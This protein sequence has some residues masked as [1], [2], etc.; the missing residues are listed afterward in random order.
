MTA[1]ELSPPAARPSPITR[2]RLIFLG[3]VVLAGSACVAL[4]VLGYIQPVVLG[5][6]QGLTEFMPV[7]SAAH[8]ILM[9]WFFH[10][11]SGM[12][13][14]LNFDLALHLGTLIALLCYFW[15]DWAE[16]LGSAPGTVRWGLR[17]MRGDHFYKPS[18]GEH[19]LI[20]MILATIPGIL[21]GVLLEPYVQHGLLRSPRLLAFT[22]TLGG[23]LLYMADTR[24][25]ERLPLEHISFRQSL[26]IGLAQSCALIPGLSRMAT[27]ITMGRLLTIDRSAATRYSFLLSAPITLAAIVFNL[28][29]LVNIPS[30]EIAFF[31]AGVLVS[32]IIGLLTIHVLLDFVGRFGFG[33]FAV[34]RALL[35]IAIVTVYFMRT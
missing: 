25:P 6:V 12:T 7:S 33:A 14:S 5:I 8:L 22:L 19:V 11:Q 4:A 17:R 1:Q 24:R 16:I 3:L 35:A 26:L 34:Y 10:W 28:D 15:R 2:G 32:A 20:S 9:R 21:L 30:N 31:A 18:L 27:T 23:L 29:A 13:D